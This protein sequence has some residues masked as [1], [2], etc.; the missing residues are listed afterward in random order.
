MIVVLSVGL[1]CTQCPPSYFVLCID[2]SA[3]IIWGYIQLLIQT[4]ANQYYLL[5][6]IIT[7]NCI[8][9]RFRPLKAICALTSWLCNRAA[10]RVFNIQFCLKAI[11][12]TG[13]LLFLSFFFNSYFLPRSLS[14]ILKP[15]T[16]WV[17]F[18]MS[19]C[20]LPSP[21]V[22]A[23]LLQHERSCHTWMDY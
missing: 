17:F 13:F 20:N 11:P 7:Y 4:D 2:A 8:K 5:N 16:A 12:F 22:V 15:G 19:F 21:A 14:F 18:P 6:F 10:W 1:H 9:Q 3:F 23:W